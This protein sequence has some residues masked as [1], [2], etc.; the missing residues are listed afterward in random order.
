MLSENIYLPVNDITKAPRIYA[1]GI[2]GAITFFR[3]EDVEAWPTIN[4]QTGMVTS[5]ITLKA[6]RSVYK[7]EATDKDKTFNE[8]LK[9]GSVEGSYVDMAVTAVVTGNTVGNTL[10]IQAM[11]YSEYGLI[12][13]D[14]CGIVRLI[15]NEDS[16]ARFSY[17]YTTGDIDS[18]RK[19]SI[20]WTWQS[21]Q[22]APIYTAT[23]FDIVVGGVPI[24]AGTLT[25][26]MRFRVGSTGAPMADGDTV[27]TNA[28][29]A[30]LNLLILADGIGL[31]I[32]D[33]SGAI[34]WTGVITRHTE[35]TFASSTITF[36]GGVIQDEIIEIY[37]WS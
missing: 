30:N 10:A 24:T 3:K 20:K 9:T 19:R 22:E 15:G 13:P 14:R 12:V 25:L 34:N 6:G 31:P 17:S 18:T 33:G 16:G 29:L 1:G 7:C 5:A 32:D 36:V 28:E 35:K 11:K 8:E 21:P 23:A 37:A 4:P 2:C 27:L 26:I